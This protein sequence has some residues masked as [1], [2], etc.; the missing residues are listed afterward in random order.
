MKNPVIFLIFCVIFF[1]Y[2]YG[3]RSAIPN[4]LNEN[5]QQF[6]NI[7]TAQMGSLISL[8]YLGYTIMQIPVG[9]ILDRVNLKKALLTSF[10]L[11]AAGIIAFV[12]S[13][14]YAV[15][16][17]AQL[18][19]GI[20]SSFSFVLLLKATND[21]FPP[22][23]VALISSIAISI[24]NFGPVVGNPA[25]AYLSTIFHW[26]SV[27]LFMGFFG[28][29]VSCLGVFLIEYD[30]KKDESENNLDPKKIFSDLKNVLM[31]RQYFFIG[32]FSMMMLGPM[33]ALC[34]AWGVSFFSQCYGFSK[35]QAA[36][37]CSMIYI[38]TIVGGPFVAHLCSRFKSYKKIMLSGSL[39]F[40]ILYALMIFV[41][42]PTIVLYA[43]MLLAGVAMSSQFLAFPVALVIADKNL[44]ATVTGFVNTFTMLGCTL[45]IGGV[46]FVVN[47]SKGS[48][49]YYSVDDYKM[50]LS[51]AIVALVI[52]V[53]SAMLIK[54]EFPQENK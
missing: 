54:V 14:S 48:N 29:L 2:Q 7:N 18:F 42:F 30:H 33:S 28:L 3:L 26:K 25:L 31:N 23:K 49:I 24:G 5:L 44:G 46:G 50:G 47:L 27:V 40:A 11:F 17:V 35:E 15:A 1:A 37:A 43:I 4:V 53:L 21:N 12:G 13:Q 38:G 41:K 22:E 8:F 10:A 9:I 51:I 34:D 39:S 16:A 36:L 32:L 20:S 6:F 52:S 19:L 45:L